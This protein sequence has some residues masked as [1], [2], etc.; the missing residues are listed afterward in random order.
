[1]VLSLELD[2][3]EL[4]ADDERRRLDGNGETT[5]LVAP[6]LSTRRT[7]VREW[8]IFAAVSEASLSSSFSAV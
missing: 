3:V 2:V 7:V 5:R 1:M 8:G 6:S 4:C